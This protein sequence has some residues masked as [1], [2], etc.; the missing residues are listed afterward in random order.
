MERVAREAELEEE[1]WQAAAAVVE[2]EMEL[3]AEQDAR[4]RQKREAGHVNWSLPENLEK[5]KPA[6]EG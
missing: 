6:V 2:K 5:L 3:K 1:E 4:K